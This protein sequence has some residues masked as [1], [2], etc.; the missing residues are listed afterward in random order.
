[1][2]RIILIYGILAG[3]VII[4]SLIAGLVLN[5]RH[6]PEWA[7]YLIM[8]AALSLIFVGVKRY[9]DTMKGGVI[10]FFEAAGVGLGI[11]AV[12]SII[13]VAGWE[14]YLWATDY[15]FF[16]AYMKGAIAA[17]KAA[18][19]SPAE[20]AKLTADMTAMA[21]AYANPLRRMGITLLEILPVGVAVAIFS[22]G[23]LRFSRLLPAR[24]HL[25]KS[26]P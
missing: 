16:A 4:G 24:T 5:A 13:Y 1:M 17:K 18:G 25:P 15:S 26:S 8:L 20:L 10:R 7:G 9:R 23:L 3:A 11:A 2:I 12:A 6:F 14:I 19:A 21:K 22:A